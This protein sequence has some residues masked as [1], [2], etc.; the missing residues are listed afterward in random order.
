[1]S[2]E[3]GSTGGGDA[4]DWR[5]GVSQSYRN[6]EVREIAKVLA[7]LEPG[8]TSASKLML[9]MRFEDTIF[10]A[11]TSLAD[12]RKKL[13]KRLKKVQKSFVPTNAVSASNK[14]Q[15]IKDLRNKYGDALR[16]IS[17]HAP[18]AIQELKN[19]HGSEKA[20]Q[21]QQHTTVA[22][23]WAEDLGLLNNT[24]PNFNMP[25]DQV[26]KL[27]QHLERRIENI[28]S[29]V[30]KLADPDLFLMETLQKAEQ[31]M[32]SR[33]SAFLA[34]N[35]KKRF[36]QLTQGQSTGFDANK[37]L[38]DSLEKAQEAV[39]PPTRSN[40][41]DEKAAILHLEK[42]RAAATA[43]LACMA[44]SDKTT[45]SR[46]VLVKSHTVATE[47]MAFVGEVIKNRRKETK[48][49]E[50]SLQDAWIKSID[51]NNTEALEAATAADPNNA[52][53]VVEVP[54]PPIGVTALKRPAIRSRVLLTKGR[55]TPSNLLAALRRK[56]A[57]LV[58]PAPHGEGSHL[59]LHFGKAFVMTIYLVPLLVT[60]RAYDKNQEL[61]PQ[62]RA[63]G[64]TCASYTP[65]EEGLREMEVLKC[66]GVTGAYDTI[67]HVVEARLEDAS[68]QAT[69]CLRRLFASKV[70]KE[71]A[72]E[73]EVEILEA[74]ALL[75]FLHNARKTYLPDWQDDD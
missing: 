32:G 34:A 53:A 66:W 12:Y 58:R 73:F 68:A 70:D 13:T 69:A 31:D 20:N 45:A 19:K 24:Q 4:D 16:F 41:N 72:P 30:V 52:D 61:T 9:A 26:Q 55:K 59:I 56:R 29:H 8:A 74:T 33:A 62:N 23:S 46:N 43:V 39:P 64:L 38:E 36:E 60:I 63:S 54:K 2:S 47:G 48:E 49:T 22:L 75:E 27:K 15:L 25:D 14:E 18:K 3:Q 35:T 65:V 67:G 17:K 50:L 11:A 37:V 42:M 6:T 10:K 1:M 57:T 28:R 40:K 44:V 7:A 5:L 71:N 21:L 51:N